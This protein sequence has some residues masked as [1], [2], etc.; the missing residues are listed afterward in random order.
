M[1][2]TLKWTALNFV[3]FAI[4]GIG[5]VILAT[6][7]DMAHEWWERLNKETPQ[8]KVTAYIRAV[9]RDDLAAAT[10]L[11]PLDCS[12]DNERTIAFC[13]RRDEV[14]EN[15]IETGIRQKVTIQSIEWWS[16][17]CEPGVIDTPEDAGLARLHVTVGNGAQRHN[18]VFDVQTK[19]GPYWGAAMDYP[20][21]QWQIR[22]VYSEGES[23]LYWKWDTGK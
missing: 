15:L 6:Q 2:R 1:K 4:I 16:T 7:V 8:A 20:V 13:Q 5:L 18:Y 9:A 17:C 3:I 11:W 19:G 14:T 22:D 23:P 12:A 21:R 10:Q